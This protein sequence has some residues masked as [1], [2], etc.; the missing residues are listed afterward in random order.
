MGEKVL[1]NPWGVGKRGD[2]KDLLP[3]AGRKKGGTLVA[4][5]GGGRDPEKEETAGI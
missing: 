3:G 2:W 1:G 5:H 4:A